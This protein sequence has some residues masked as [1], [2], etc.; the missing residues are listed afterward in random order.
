MIIGDDCRP[1][2]TGR[3]ECKLD[4]KTTPC[5]NWPN[6]SLMNAQT[7]NNPAIGPPIQK[8]RGV[9][10]RAVNNRNRKLLIRIHP[11]K[12]SR[13]IKKATVPCSK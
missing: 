13:Q 9:I 3:Y 8:S 11:F 5:L 6:N 7:V 10:S 1:Y 2:A 12:Q 4:G